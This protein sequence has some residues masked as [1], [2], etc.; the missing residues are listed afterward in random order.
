MLI[1]FNGTT[2]WNTGTKW[3]KDVYTV[4]CTNVCARVFGKKKTL[5]RVSKKVSNEQSESRT[6]N[7]TTKFQERYMFLLC[8]RVAMD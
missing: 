4:H 7:V 2:D 8:M 6:M 1:R 3:N 5:S